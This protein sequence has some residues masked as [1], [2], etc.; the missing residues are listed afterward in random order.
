MNQYLH[1]LMVT[2]ADPNGNTNMHT[3]YRDAANKV[4]LVDKDCTS[5]DGQTVYRFEVI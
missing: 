4:V 1:S 5:I 2:S 3:G